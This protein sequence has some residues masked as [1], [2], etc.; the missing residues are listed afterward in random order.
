MSGEHELPHRVGR[1]FVAS[2]ARPPAAVD[3]SAPMSDPQGSTHRSQFGVRTTGA[4]STQI[5]DQTPGIALLLSDVVM[6]GGIDGRELAVH[7]R[8]RC[9]VPKVVLMSG[10][11]PDSG[12]P[13]DGPM[14]AKPFTR[15]Q[16]AALLE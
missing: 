8:E 7:A 5:L 14:L 2:D 3:D 15:M 16:L 6:P 4:T 1:A 11:A 13:S 9:G 10:Y 12:Q